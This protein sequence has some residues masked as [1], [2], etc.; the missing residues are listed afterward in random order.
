MIYLTRI[1]LVCFVGVSGSARLW[2]QEREP[3]APSGPERDQLEAVRAVRTA[4]KDGRDQEV[5]LLADRALLAMA[6]DGDL[7]MRAPE[8]H[9]WRGAALRR[10]GRYDEAVVA[11][12]LAI[13]LGFRGPEVHL[14][15]GLAHRGLGRRQEAD[16][17]YQE[18]ERLLP[19]D[20]EMRERLLHR[21]KWDGKDQARLQ[22]LA[23]PQLGFDT[24]IVGLDERTP[25]VQDDV[26]FD[27]PYAGAFLEAKYFPILNDRQLLWIGYQNLVRYYTDE[28]DVSFTDNVA[29]LVGRQPLFEDFDLEARASLEEA[30]LRE[31]GHFRT[32]RTVGPAALWRP[33]RPLHLRLWADWTDADYYAPVPAEQDRDGQIVRGGLRLT[34]DLGRGWSAAPFVSLNRYDAEGSDYESRGWEAGLSVTPAELGGIRLVASLAYGRQDYENPNSLTGFAEKRSDRPLSASLVVTLRML[35]GVLGYAPTLSVAYMRH[36]STIDNFDYD[37]WTPQIELG[38]A[39]LSF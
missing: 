28:P 5:L 14:E 30:F 31:D 38:I 26:D 13:T 9:F 20:P 17:D 16:R 37:R 34:L 33:V 35:E 27:S 8:L 15:R 23:S 6:R 25:L 36:R 32:Q 18:A 24:N 39:A 10:L 29:T 11:L 19:E 12:D 2:A 7:A 1:A 3:A 21:W 4:Y 22:V